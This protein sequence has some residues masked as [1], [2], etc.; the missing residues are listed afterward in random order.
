MQ[1]L[2]KITNVLVN[3]LYSS[4]DL[5]YILKCSDEALSKKD[6]IL[7]FAFPGRWHVESKALKD[8]IKEILVQILDIGH[9]D[10]EKTEG[11][12][13]VIVPL[14]SIDDKTLLPNQGNVEVP[15]IIKLL[16]N[17]P[18]GG[19]QFKCYQTLTIITDVEEEEESIEEIEEETLDDYFELPDE[20]ELISDI[21]SM[22]EL[23][24]DDD[25]YD[26]ESFGYATEYDI[27]PDEMGE[28]VPETLQQNYSGV[29]A[30]DFG[31]TNSVVVVRDPLYAAEEIRED[32][33]REQWNSLGKWVDSWI[34]QHLSVITPKEKDFFVEEMTSE[35][36]LPPCGSLSVDIWE[37]LQKVDSEQKSKLLRAIISNLSDYETNEENTTHRD[38]ASEL[39]CGFEQ[40]IYSKSFE[41]QRYFILE[42]DENA[43][44]GPISSALQIVSAPPSNEQDLLDR[45]TQVEMGDR[46]HLLMRSAVLREA[47]IRQFALTVKRYFGQ[48]QLVELV[49]SETASTPISFSPDIL[50][51][52]AYK[53]LISRALLN[54]QERANQKEFKFADS[55]RTMVATFPTTYPASLRR[56]LRDMMNELDIEAIDT[57]FDEGTASAIYYIWRE[58]CADPICGMHGLMARCRRDRHGRSYQNI[59]LYDLG[60][61]TTDIALIQLIYEELPIFEPIDKTKSEGGRY[62]R[63]TPRLLGSTGHRYIGGDLITLWLFRLV[64]SKLADKLLILLLERH[65][66]PPPD[67]PFNQV[68][69][70]LP[71]EVCNADGTYR[72]EALLDWSYAPNQNIRD[73]DILNKNIINKIIPTIFH[74]DGSCTPNFFTLWDLTEDAKKNLGVPV[75]SFSGSGLGS[76]WLSKVTL[77]STQLWRFITNTHPWLEEVGVTQEDIIVE[78]YQEELCRVT[79][80]VVDESLSLAINLAKARLR[81][82][83]VSDKL[84][85]FILSG[86]SCNLQIV[87]QEAKV[88]FLKTE[89]LFDFNI[90]NVFFEPE[91][92]K[93]SVAMGACIGRYLES[94][95][96]D[97]SHEKTKQMLREGYDQ[98]DLVVENLF[99][100]LAC[101]LVYDSLVAMVQIFDHGQ[102]LNQRSFINGRPVARTPMDDLRPVQEK[103]WIYRVDFEGASPQYLGLINAEHAALNNGFEDFRKFREQ[104]IV[105]FEADAELFVRAFFLPRGPKNILALNFLDDPTF[106]CPASDIIENHE[107]KYAK[108]TNNITSQE[109]FNRRVVIA[110][111]TEMID[112]IEYPDGSQYRC[113][114]S[115]P[116][117]IR[118][119]YYFYIE[120]LEEN[121]DTEPQL[122]AHFNLT[123]EDVDEVTLACDETGRVVLLLSTTYDIKI[124]ADINY[125]PQKVDIQYDPFCGQH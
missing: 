17:S 40:T 52:L 75:S 82:F 41:S 57:R 106:F 77:E 103:L 36:D 12:F 109:L 22:I 54:I 117:P 101:R 97:P 116:L 14:K 113:A 42:L 61:G 66:D 67:S 23:P 58:V 65:I 114:L 9:F 102:E 35:F 96:I 112:T 37:E 110:S 89:E 39:L 73:F 31:T 118:E 91:L 85:R 100:N 30:I 8:R 78:I 105:G 107:K 88:L 18:G 62:F 16:K 48:E 24:D 6:L 72:A 71:D 125:L 27:P 45:E 121:A 1:F 63:I 87:Q 92:A 43:G 44:P 19:V 50:C 49:P 74:I 64:K 33:S 108:L 20:D 29:M 79:R 99:T 28:D 81:T 93:T 119:M 56:K 34:I 60:G 115:K 70:S 15:I 90:A 53:K 98:V 122:I 94:V 46:V 47:D 69:S 25:F 123:D 7:K 3:P 51:R 120:N 55:I 80:D 68:L 83:D 21:D 124:W 38:I 84:D 10:I 111:N 13:F 104:Y 2:P 95:R 76:E 32:L 11:G 5:Q 26:A 4:E 86:L 59:L